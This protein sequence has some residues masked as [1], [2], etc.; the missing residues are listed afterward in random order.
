MVNAEHVASV[1][2]WLG[3]GP[4]WHPDEQALYW[5]DLLNR[6]VYRYRPTT[7]KPDAFE[8]SVAITVLGLRAAG[9][10]VAATTDGFAFWDSGR[11]EVELIV[12]PEAH[13]AYTRFNDGA[14]DCAGRFWAG[15]MNK[16]IEDPSVTDGSLYRLDP[17]GSCHKMGAGFTVANGIGWSL[18]H[19]TMYFADTLRSVIYAYDFDP[20]GG[21]IE[22]RRPFA[23]VS[24]EEGYPDGLTVDSEGCVWSAL[25]GG[26]K[27][28]RF[29]P[30]GR[31][32]DEVRLPASNVSSCAFGGPD[33]HDLYVTSAWESLSA[34]ERKQQP[35][36][37]DLFRVRL[38][39]GG[40]EEPRFA[41]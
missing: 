28:V 4:I 9:G 39:V 36:A 15:T 33:L 24:P 27:V 14:V 7:G 41:G 12:N 34:E 6:R 2:N 21:T 1:Q 25:W 23:Q 13:L 16:D 17:D 5:V 29:D 32:V 35:L 22:N 31:A 19:R 8:A 20:V 11:R 38:P 10:W 26:W 40:L 30:A 37:G 3:E 18:D